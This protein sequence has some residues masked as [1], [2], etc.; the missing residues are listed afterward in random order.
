MAIWFPLTDLL[1]FDYM[2]LGASLIKR[3]YIKAKTTS[4]EAARAAR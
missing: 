4:N 2:T 3:R 1:L